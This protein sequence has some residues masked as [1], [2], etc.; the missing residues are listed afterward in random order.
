MKLAAAYARIGWRVVPLHDVTAG[1]CSCGDPA[2]RSAGKH[3][4]IGAWQKEASSDLAV[5]E[6]WE[7]QY[8]NA[9]VGIATG[10]G[11][12]ALDV[13]GDEGRATLA[14]MGVDL[15][16][17][18]QARTGSGGDHY[19]YA[20]PPGVTVRNSASK[21]GHKVDVRGIGGQIVVAPSVSL[22]GPYKW[23]RSPMTGMALAPDWLLEACRPRPQT[24]AAAPAERGFF[25]PASPA[26]LESAAEALRAHGSAVEGSGGDAHTF[27]AAAILRHDFALTEEEAWP[28][29]LEWNSTCLPPWSE[30]DLAAKMRGGDEYGTGAYGSRR[31]LA[32]DV[33]PRVRQMFKTWRESG[34][35]SDGLETIGKELREMSEGADP[36]VV[37]LVRK[38]WAAESGLGTRA[39]SLN[40]GVIEAGGVTPDGAIVVTVKLHEVADQATVTLQEDIY[41]RHGAVCEVA[42]SAIFD[43]K[44]AR[45]QDLMSRRGK[46]VREDEKGIQQVAPPLAIAEIIHSRRD[47]G[48]AIRPLDAVVKTPILLPDG[49]ILQEPGYNATTRVYL[50]PSVTVSVADA[51]SLE[52]ARNAIRTLHALLSDFRFSERADF[53]SW[54]ATLLT[55]LAKAAL[56]NAPAP[57]LCISAPTG[58]TGKSLLAEVIARIINGGPL[59]TQSYERNNPGEMMKRITSKLL[60]AAPLAVF[61]DLNGR[62]GP[63][64]TLDRLLTSAV[65]SERLLGG[66]D[67]PDLPNV[68][69]WIATGNN[70]EPCGMT[71]RR[72]LVCRIDTLEEN[73]QERGGFR[74]KD[75]KSYAKDHRA[76]LL[77]AA[78]TVLR[79]YC[80]VGKPDQ[81][82][83][84]W[85]SFEEWSALIR[86][87]IVW[88]GL[89]DPYLTQKRA[90][91]TMNDAERDA[92]D[93]WISVVEAA[94]DGSPAS[95]AALANL[96][97]AHGILGHRE[98]FH[99]H[100]VNAWIQRHV[101]RPRHGKRI[102]RTSSVDGPR[103]HVEKI[104]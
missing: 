41:H 58:G 98:A 95:I 6:A 36:I 97:D 30:S 35:T 48:D 54:L 93:F 102:R 85:G 49:S 99:A 82:L 60:S 64:E 42:G 46:Y 15:P 88:T 29:L 11:W 90:L 56:G 18:V 27:H 51:P 43:L 20:L 100:S 19:L 59:Q 57:M 7:R 74:I 66:N 34:A 32:S 26:V 44:T 81:N 14:A 53:S 96:R 39:L 70:I 65:W 21:I 71:V 76:E 22:K 2:C 5:V 87:A 37:E 86:G 55:P 24:P 52:D 3:P 77:T 47:H 62:F 1:V 104:A 103:Y 91:A 80:A 72:V 28:L 67:V 33:L 4:R 63:D 25:P 31:R 10:H 16:P 45:I 79:A 78:L 101:D 69:T 84:S 50:K 8:P 13:D 89:P 17:T 40:A 94:P 23:V 83:P 61:D 73:P 38:E 12:I 9:N 68:T 75:L 92:L